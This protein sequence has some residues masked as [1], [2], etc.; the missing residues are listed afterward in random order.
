MK[1]KVEEFDI[2]NEDMLWE[3]FMIFARRFI[4]WEEQLK[5]LTEEQKHPMY[6]FIYEAEVMGEGHIGF[7][8]LHGE[9]I[10]IEEVITALKKL[11]VAKEY[12]ENLL[13]FPKAYISDD[14]LFEG[15]VD[16]SDFALQMEKR[17]KIYEG[18]DEKFYDLGNEEIEDKIIQ[19]VQD[20]YTAF[21]KFS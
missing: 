3:N 1:V 18:Y 5:E 14:I 2:S 8:E 19:Y 9:Y 10:D 21:F 7:M 15:A 17:D 11:D 13:Q 20:H 16:E 6:A 4:P 12:I